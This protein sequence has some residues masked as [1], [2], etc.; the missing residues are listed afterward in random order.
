MERR[1]RKWKALKMIDKIQEEKLKRSNSN[2]QFINMDLE[3][4]KQMKDGQSYLQKTV[5]SKMTATL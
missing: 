3:S 1:K 4:H 5:Q 2:G